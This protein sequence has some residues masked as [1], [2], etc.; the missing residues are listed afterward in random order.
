MG[1]GVW[2]VKLL[3]RIVQ[4]LGSRLQG[5]RFEDVGFRVGAELPS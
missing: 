1:F 5:V 2:G 4:G 3:A